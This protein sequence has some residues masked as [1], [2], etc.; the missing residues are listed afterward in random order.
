MISEIKASIIKTGKEY[1]TI[2]ALSEEVE[3]LRRV[4]DHDSNMYVWIVAEQIN[5]ILIPQLQLK[6]VYADKVRVQ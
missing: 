1:P 5:T 4:L 2:L 6:I 3:Y